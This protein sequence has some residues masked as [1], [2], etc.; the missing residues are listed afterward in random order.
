VETQ[1]AAAP[2]S[3]KLVREQ[4]KREPVTRI[5]AVEVIDTRQ[6]AVQNMVSGVVE[7]TML[8]KLENNAVAASFKGTTMVLSARYLMWALRGGSAD[9]QFPGLRPAAVEHFTILAEISTFGAR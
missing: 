2:P 8:D 6:S 4:P 3:D 7:E 9:S 1:V 5:E